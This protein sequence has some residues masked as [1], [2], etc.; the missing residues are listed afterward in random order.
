MCRRDGG[1][2]TRPCACRLPGKHPHTL[3]L[4]APPGTSTAPPYSVPEWGQPTTLSVAS[5]LSALGKLLLLLPWWS[6]QFFLYPNTLTS[7]LPVFSAF[8]LS[9]LRSYLHFRSL[10]SESA[11]SPGKAGWLSALQDAA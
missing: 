5:S 9:F 3:T 7:R 8:P 10:A 11:L 4:L 2:L 6:F 1:V